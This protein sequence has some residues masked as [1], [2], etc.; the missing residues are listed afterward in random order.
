MFSY[1]FPPVYYSLSHF[2][3]KFT[4]QFVTCLHKLSINIADIKK[5][6]QDIE[7]SK[8]SGPNGI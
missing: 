8:G 4:S 2:L 6:L 1:H 5:S 3:S 7:V